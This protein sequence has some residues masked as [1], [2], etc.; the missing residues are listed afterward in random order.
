[1]EI[2][3][4]HGDTAPSFLSKLPFLH[5]SAFLPWTA[6][7]FWH[8]KKNSVWDMWRPRN[9]S[10]EILI[11]LLVPGLLGMTFFR[12]T[13]GR[14]Q[15]LI[16][17]LW[18][19]LVQPTVL[20]IGSVVCIIKGK[21]HIEDGFLLPQK[22]SKSSQHGK[23][24]LG[25]H[26]SISREKRDQRMFSETQP[27][28]LIIGCVPVCFPSLAVIGQNHLLSKGGHWDVESGLSHFCIPSSIH[29]PC[30]TGSF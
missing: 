27:A 14:V 17:E 13:V 25:L 16:F 30:L 2:G 15:N 24:A 26:T 23:G 4:N 10:A 22:L 5:S 19:L 21:N 1:M 6:Q 12:H 3:S 20:V 11:W 9:Y 29:C 7:L 8:Q 18:Y 28:N